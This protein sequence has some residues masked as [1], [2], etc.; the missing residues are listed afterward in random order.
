MY[1]GI[2]LGTT[3][4]V[5][6]F[7]Q[8]RRDGRIIASPIEIDRVMD[9]GTGIEGKVSYSRSRAKTLPSCVYYGDIPIVGD[10]AREQYKKYPERVAK[11]IKSQM[12]NSV[13]RGLS[14]EIVDKTPEAVSA[15]ILKHL[16]E[17]GQKQIRQT[18][19]Q[20]IITVPA[21]FDAARREA[22][23]RAAELAGFD[24]REPDRSWKPILI[25]E[26]NAVLYDL[27]QK[28]LNGEVAESVLDLSEKKKV[29]VF[30]IGGGTLDV[31][32]HEIE[33]DAENGVTL[34]I[35]EIAASRF[36]Q[37]AGDDFDAAIAE[38]LYKRC[39]DK[40]N[41]Y[42]PS[43]VPRIL[44]R[45]PMVKK[46]LT[47][48]AERLKIDMN[49]NVENSIQGE[50]DDWFGEA[51]DTNDQDATQSISHSIGDERIYNDTITKSEFE[52]MLEPFMG[53]EYT[54]SDYRGYSNNK[55]IRR[56]TIVAPILDVLE[57]AARFYTQQGEPLQVDAV[58]LN[59][60]MSK[61]YLVKDRIRNFFDLEPI[62]TADPDL[63]V[64]NGAAVYAAIQDMYHLENHITIKRHVQNDD[65]YLG[66]AAGV[67][68]LLISTG[69]ELPYT[70]EIRGYR[71][72]P[73]TQTLEIP[74]KRG[75]ENGEPQIIARGII[76][77][78][79]ERKTYTD[80]K[81]EASFDQTGLLAIQAFLLNEEGKS[82]ETGSVEFAIG[83][84]MEKS[85][86]GDRILPVSGAKLMPANEI[87]AL[88]SLFSDK[89]KNRNKKQQIESK[90]DTILHCGNPEDFEEVILRYLSE[91][92]G[93]GF[94]YYLY[95][96]VAGLAPTWSDAGIKRLKEVAQR[97]VISLDFGFQLEEKRKK[98]SQFVQEVLAG[99]EK[100]NTDEWE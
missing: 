28:L 47:V 73:G 74:I 14:E 83:A 49:A 10:Y 40:F 24:V 65:L 36:T 60:G 72:L 93:Y 69:D 30:D 71:I 1:I 34:H 26:P 4:S 27:A 57:K 61:L 3:N 17:Q 90:M 82:V 97:D 64:A 33:Q 87:D 39:V 11:S 88:K 5:I 86:G 29:L 6:S 75:E 19:H 96:I 51:F 20:V 53:N 44:E 9:S 89:N 38:V 18:I 81:I 16:K 77:F 94:R 13:T 91:N 66:L 70:K 35:S 95:Q 85:R 32:F 48:A 80:L 56:D 58:I 76:T 84:P 55:K 2:D 7:A 52:A 100:G 99:I 37:L 78:S 42:E 54:F 45:A 63:S 21:N 92:N 25:S 12:G 43:A 59:G 41:A 46:M 8:V 62:T 15:R 68:D 67:N 79:K 50:S 23:M 31:T 98:L 22:T